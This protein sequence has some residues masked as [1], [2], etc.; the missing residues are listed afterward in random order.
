MTETPEN[1]RP[2]DNRTTS[3]LKS[4]VRA[5]GRSRSAGCGS[6]PSEQPPLSSGWRGETSRTGVLPSPSHS[7][8]ST[9][10]RSARPR[11]SIAMSTWGPS[12]PWS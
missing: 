5:Y 12:S 10:C 7:A 9:G 2:D 4:R 1:E 11:F 6:F 8:M 3:G